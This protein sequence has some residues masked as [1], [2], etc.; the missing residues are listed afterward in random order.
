MLNNSSAMER[1][2][3]NCYDFEKAVEIWDGLM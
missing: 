2:G 3:L 1:R